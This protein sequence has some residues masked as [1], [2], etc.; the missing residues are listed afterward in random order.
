MSTFAGDGFL[1][2]KPP[3]ILIPGSAENNI[4]YLRRDSDTV[5]VFVHGI[6]SDSRAC[7]LTEDGEG[8]YWPSLVSRDPRFD[9]ASIYLGGFHTALDSRDY[10]VRHCAGELF[11]AISRG[12]A[13]VLDK[14]RIVFVCHSTG[15][16]VTR[17]MLESRSAQ[18]AEKDIG[19]L[20]IASPSR[21]SALATRLRFLSDYFG[22]GLAKQL[23]SGN[24]S[25]DELDDRFWRLI[26]ERRI[27][28]LSGMEAFEH[29]FVLHSKFVNTKSRVVPKESAERYFPPAR[30][31]PHTNHFSCVKPN[32]PNHPAHLLLVDFCIQF[33]LGVQTELRHTRSRVGQTIAELRRDLDLL[34]ALIE[35]L[36]AESPQRHEEERNREQLMNNLRAER[37]LAGFRRL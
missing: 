29:H 10:T 26:H 7:W 12:A 21:G 6:F 18:F 14:R 22:N 30:L 9:E 32:G 19:I 28:R 8:E 37:P 15:G 13:S 4:W 3:R 23:E 24:D 11:A 35:S 31:L 36:P 34:D 17:Y 27:R 20:L 33:G 1:R 25:L 5:I 2:P 16:I